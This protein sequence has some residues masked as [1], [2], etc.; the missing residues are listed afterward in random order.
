MHLPARRRDPVSLGSVVCLLEIGL[1][2]RIGDAGRAAGRRHCRRRRAGRGGRLP[3]RPLAPRRP[4]HRARRWR[5]AEVVRVPEELEVRPTP[6]R[7]RRP[8]HAARLVVGIALVVVTAAAAG[9]LLVAAAALGAA[10]WT[11]L[12]VYARREF[13]QQ[14]RFGAATLV[15]ACAF[16][17]W[18]WLQ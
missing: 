2:Q 17:A 13:A 18:V 7:P 10:L 11:W 12:G 4:P 14:W 6:P 9:G 1:E 3:L 16:L 5:V 15:P 8:T